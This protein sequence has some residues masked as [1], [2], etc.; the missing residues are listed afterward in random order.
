MGAYF[1]YTMLSLPSEVQHGFVVYLGMGWC[2]KRGPGTQHDIHQDWAREKRMPNLGVHL[3]L[4]R[5]LSLC[6]K[7]CP[8][9]PRSRDE[10]PM[11]NTAWCIVHRLM[12]SSSHTGRA[13][14]KMSRQQITRNIGAPNTKHAQIY[15]VTSKA[16]NPM[17]SA[18]ARPRPKTLDLQ[19]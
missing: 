4:S 7:P 19:I 2:M 1:R 13:D 12:M 17:F 15:K 9:T 6:T 16:E 3:F 8:D 11:A 10:F 5:A 14:D 18:A